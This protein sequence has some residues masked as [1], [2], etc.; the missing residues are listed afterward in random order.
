M[1]TGEIPIDAAVPLVMPR[2]SLLDADPELLTHVAKAETPRARRS[3][4]VPLLVLPEGPFD[5]RVALRPG[6]NTFG[7]VVISGLIAREVFVGGQPALRLLGPGDLL[8]DM[9]LEAGLVE[10]SES[11]SA[12]LPTRLGLLDDHFLHAVRHWPRLMTAIYERAAE[13]HDATLLQ[14]AISQHPRVEDRL[15]GLFAIL[16]ERWGRVT[17]HGVVLALA[18]THEALARLVGARR[19]TVTL[20]LGV[21][22]ED[23]R[24]L[25]RIDGGWLLGAELLPAAV[26]PPEPL[27]GKAR[28]RL[29]VEVERAARDPLRREDELRQV[30]HRVR[31]LAAGHEHLRDGVRV[32]AAHTEEMR[33][34]TDAL[35]EQGRVRRASRAAVH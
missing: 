25:K 2:I 4:S 31:T 24:V 1:S 18:L 3:V 14:L 33:R 10:A 19:P 28:P 17:P 5:P 23:G 11:W 16:A 30:L 22:A 8:A 27:S 26:A 21:L 20:A 32:L 9:P 35:L 34:R 13:R 29:V 7:A 12:S 6:R 15:A